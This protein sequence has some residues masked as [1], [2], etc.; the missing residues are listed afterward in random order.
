MS[1]C[2]DTECCK[3]VPK[4][5]AGVLKGAAGGQNQERLHPKGG[6]SVTRYLC[7][8]SLL[9]LLLVVVVVVVVVVVL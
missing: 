9:P 5:I 1:L 2:C 6:L 4:N 7:V 8:C 3:S